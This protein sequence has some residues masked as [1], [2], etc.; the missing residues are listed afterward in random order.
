MLPNAAAGDWRL[1]VKLLK[2]GAGS[3]YHRHCVETKGQRE[4]QAK[5]RALQTIEEFD[6]ELTRSGSPMRALELRFVSLPIPSRAL[7]TRIGRA[8]TGGKYHRCVRDAQGRSGSA[9]DVHAATL[10]GK[11]SRAPRLYRKTPRRFLGL[12]SLDDLRHWMRVE[13]RHRRQS[14]RI[15]RR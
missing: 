2:P 12:N 8:R 7:W 6:F 10:P 9:K 11:R 15:L 5:V 14:E 1:E 13:G 4:A 3:G